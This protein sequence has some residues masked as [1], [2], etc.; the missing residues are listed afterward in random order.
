TRK[1]RKRFFN[2]CGLSWIDGK[3]RDVLRDGKKDSCGC[4][5]RPSGHL[6]GYSDFLPPSRPGGGRTAAGYPVL[7][8]F[9]SAHAVVASD[10]GK[11]PT[12]G[13]TNRRR[14]SGLFDWLHPALAAASS[15]L[16]AQSCTT[17]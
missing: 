5:V 4:E 17:S 16:S 2:P 10:Q 6:A 14:E 8:F 3:G 12:L 11:D 13:I 9:S 1:P 7:G 15:G